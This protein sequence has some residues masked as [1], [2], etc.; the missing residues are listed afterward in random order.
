MIDY[1]ATFQELTD[2]IALSCADGLD[3]RALIFA[4][5][6][7]MARKVPAISC[8]MDSV[9][10]LWTWL[11]KSGIK[12]YAR[13]H[14]LD[15]NFDEK[16]PDKIGQ[17]AAT[18][19]SAFKKGARG[20][21]IIAS[22]AVHE[23]LATAL[24]PIAADLFFGRELILCADLAD[25]QPHDWNGLF[26]NMKALGATGLGLRI[27]QSENTAGAFYGMLDAYA[28]ELDGALHIISM[29]SAPNSME[30]IWRL[31]KKIRPDLTERITFF[32]SPPC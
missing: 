16:N 8:D 1:T 6:K 21:Q 25:I 30:D 12:I 13:M 27:E 22:P 14:I 17:V 10:M 26:H 9:N 4:A 32:V 24:A 3:A 20:V 29:D 15:E 5:D 23:K 19:H 2:N 11:E 28:P 18:I 7:A 31:V